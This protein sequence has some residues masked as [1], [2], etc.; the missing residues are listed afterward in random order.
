MEFSR[1]EYWSGLP[2]SPPGNLTHPGI[3]LGSF[4]APELYTADTLLS[5]SQG[6]EA[7]DWQCLTSLSQLTYPLKWIL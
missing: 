3:K 6:I 5:E 1:Q 4:V 7:D 2:C